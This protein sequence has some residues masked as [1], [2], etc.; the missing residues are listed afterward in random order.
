[1]AKYLHSAWLRSDPLLI[2]KP[3]RRISLKP[4]NALPDG[5]QLSGPGWEIDLF[6]IPVTNST[7]AINKTYATYGKAGDGG[8]WHSWIDVVPNLGYGIVV[9]SQMSRLENYTRI[10][11]TDIRDLVQEALMPAFAKALSTRLE[12]RFAGRYANGRDGGIFPDEVKRNGSN[13]TTYARFEVEDQILYM[14]ELVVNGTSALE[15][16]DRLSWTA[17]SQSRVFSTPDGVALT[18]AEGASENARFGPG[19]QVWRSMIPGL[20][21]CDWFDFDG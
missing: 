12:E 14:R 19:A 8:G 10:R 15:G 2:T 6:D 4:N 5:K 17:E 1:M 7:P 21:E 18:P 13:S 11:P 20:D 3:Q 9:L 16:I